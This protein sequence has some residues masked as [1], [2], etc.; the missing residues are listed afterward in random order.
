MSGVRFTSRRPLG[1]W[2]D[3]ITAD[4]ALGWRWAMALIE[5]GL[6]VNPNEKFYVSLAHTDEDVERTLEAVDEAFASLR[7]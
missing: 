6:L 4:T 5:R 2:A 1:T 3:A 7:R